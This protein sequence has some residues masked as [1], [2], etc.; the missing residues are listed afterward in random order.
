MDEGA[1]HHVLGQVLEQFAAQLFGGGRFAAQIGHQTLAVRLARIVL[2]G[3][4][5]HFA[6]TGAQGQGG[7]D[8]ADLDAQ[9]A[10]LHLEVIASQV[11]QGT[12][13]QPAAEVAGLV[14][15][16]LRLAGKR[17][18]DKTF[19]AQLWLVQVTPGHADAADMQL[20]GHAQR[21]YLAQGI[22]HMHLDIGD[23]AADRH[24]FARVAGTAL[25][26]GDVDGR[27]GRAIEVMQFDPGQLLFEA[28]LQAAGQGLAAAQHPT[29][30]GEVAGIAVFEEQVEHRRYE[31]QQGDAA[32]AHHPGQVV[33]LLVTARAGHD[34]LGTGEQ[35]QEELPDRHVE[36]ERG[37]LQ[38]TIAG[39]DGVFVAG[40]EQAVDH[41]Q[42]FVHHPFRCAGGAR[43]VEHI[44]QVA[45]QQAEGP[46]VRVVGGLRGQ[47]RA[48]VGVVEQQYRHVR[49]WQT[50][51]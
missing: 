11:F 4:Y 14:Q 8:F 47:L 12:I 35:W 18:G 34:Q 48:V 36:T 1:G 38:D 21:L 9:A 13:G 2:A 17:V 10:N 6:N 19:G 50:V 33:G 37:L 20:P 5:H 45:R 32:V 41:A 16:R 27:F 15:A 39:V 30:R 23:R 42:V 22:Q 28:P 43:G 46:G 7:L 24:A 31:V 25:P 51:Q 26:D 40:P 29:Q 44:G 49:R 3:D